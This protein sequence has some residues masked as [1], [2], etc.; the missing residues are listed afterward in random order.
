MDWWMGV[1]AD[2]EPVHH[3][4][5]IAQAFYMLRKSVDRY[6]GDN[7][8]SI[9]PVMY[10]RNAFVISID[11]ERGAVQKG[12][13]LALT[14]ISTQANLLLSLNAN[15]MAIPATTS[16]IFLHYDAIASVSLDGCTVLD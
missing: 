6:F 4:R 12:G 15:G 14:G 2:V 3:T 5:S 10:R 8:C 16:H 1:G 11:L 9:S 7:A 13:G